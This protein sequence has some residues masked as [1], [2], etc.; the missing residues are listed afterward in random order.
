[1]P[2]ADD[3][4]QLPDALPVPVDDGACDHLP[5]T[6]VPAIEL[7]ATSGRTV[8]LD[9]LPGRAVVYCYP[10]TGHPDQE[11]PPGWNAIPG[12]RGCTPETCGFRDRHGAFVDLGARVFGLSAQTTADQREMVDR[13]GVPFEVLSD[14]DLRLAGALGLPTFTVAGMTLIKRLTLVLDDGVVTHVFYPVFPPDRHAAAVLDWLTD[15]GAPA[16]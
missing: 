13:L 12:A 1:M 6:R 8:R 4:H 16:T 14:A 9:T 5:G 10:R 2:R 15:A 3:V 7:E 11:L